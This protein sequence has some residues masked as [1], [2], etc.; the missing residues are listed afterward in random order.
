VLDTSFSSLYMVPDFPSMLFL[1][2]STTSL[3]LPLIFLR[4]YSV[5]WHILLIVS[6]VGGE[7]LAHSCNSCRLSCLE[8]SRGLGDNGRNFWFNMGATQPIG[9]CLPPPSGNSTQLCG[10]D[11]LPQ[12]RNSTSIVWL[13]YLQ[14][15]WS[16][17]MQWISCVPPFF[18]LHPSCTSLFGWVV[19]RHRMCGFPLIHQFLTPSHILHPYP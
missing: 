18:P 14:L 19:C 5:V 13:R 12:S 16:W 3:I 15:F 17:Y 10:F 9:I 11:I 8:V 7:F 6:V 4:L 1:Y 2:L